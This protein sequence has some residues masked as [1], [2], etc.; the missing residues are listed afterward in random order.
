MEKTIKAGIIGCGK[1]GPFHAAAYQKIS[2]C[3]LTAVYDVQEDRADAFAAKFGCKA[4]T[5]VE[6]MIKENGLDVVSICT[7]HP[8]HRQAAVEALRCG[9]NIAIEKPLASSLEDCD[10]IL[11]AAEEH[12]ALGTAICQR[13][14]YPPTKRINQDS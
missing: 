10:A 4:Y 1:V 7:P 8:V 13:L 14:N 9:A 6:A 3:E 12:H 11:E 2:G 5:S